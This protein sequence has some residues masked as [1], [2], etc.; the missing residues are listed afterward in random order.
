MLNQ[1]ILLQSQGS[2]M[3]NLV[4]IAGIF[5][6]MYFFMIRPQSKRQKEQQAFTDALEKG[7]RVIS[8]SGIHGK[9]INIIG[10]VVTVEIAK[11]VNVKI[12]KDFISKDLSTRTETTT[13]EA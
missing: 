8:A 4:M 11:G 5:V 1:V 6:V 10:S 7:D 13:E 12:E 2:G 9:I 3:M